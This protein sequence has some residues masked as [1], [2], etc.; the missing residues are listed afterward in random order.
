MLPSAICTLVQ[1]DKHQYWTWHYQKGSTTFNHRN[2][3]L[4]W[5]EKC[6]EFVYRE[7]EQKSTPM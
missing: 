4:A 3:P 5:N 6:K 1:Q 7:H 2:K